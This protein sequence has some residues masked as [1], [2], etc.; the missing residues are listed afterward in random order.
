MEN[1][2]ICNPIYNFLLVADKKRI[3]LIEG[4]GLYIATRIIPKLT[5]KVK[6]ERTDCVD[7]VNAAVFNANVNSYIRLQSF[8]T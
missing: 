1:C 8:L 7:D 3:A 2:I 4:P 5:R 6:S